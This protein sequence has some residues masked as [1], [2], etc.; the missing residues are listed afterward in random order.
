ML[1]MVAILMSLDLQAGSWRAVNDGVMGGISS[2]G[3]VAAGD[4]LRFEGSLSLENNGGFASVRR[5]LK[6]S[7]DFESV[8]L[9]V[10]GDGRRYQFRIRQDSRFDGVSWAAEFATDGS[11]QTVDLPLSAFRAVYRGRSVPDAGPVEPAQIRQIGFL[12]AD[13]LTGSF[14]LEI[15]AIEFLGPDP[16][17]PR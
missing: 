4:G 11:W 12:I 9:R 1:T 2:G 16:D 3:I 8:R 7:A 15:A 10:R 14:A 17:A 6:P 5:E 13:K